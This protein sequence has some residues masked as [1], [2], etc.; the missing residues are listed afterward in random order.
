MKK[1]GI[2]TYQ[3]IADGKGRF[4]QAYALYSAIGKLGYEAE[5]ID[6]YPYSIEE[7]RKRGITKK[8]L[9]AIKNPRLLPG[10]IIK[11][12]YNF[13]D[14]TYK[15]ELSTKRNKYEIFIRDNINIT[16]KK[17]FG[18]E[19]LLE[20]EMCY[21]AYVCGSD[22]IWNPYFQGTDSAYFLKFAP[23]QKRIAY[24]PSLGTTQI[25]EKKKEILKLNVREMP[26]VSVREESGAKLVSELINRDV[27]NV[28]DPTLL[29]PKKW[30]DDFAGEHIQNKPYVLTFFFDNSTYPRRMANTIAQKIGCKIISIPDT[31]RDFLTINDKRI[32]IGPLEFVSLFKNARFICTQSFHG[33][34]LSLLFNKPFYVFDRQT[35]VYVSG[36]FSRI[37]E[38]LE[39]VDLKDRILAPGQNLPKEFDEIDFDHANNV[40]K[41]ERFA[42][43]K[44]LKDS[45]ENVTGAN[46]NAC[47]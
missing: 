15:K 37:Q 34:V 6:Y 14:K 8:L 27:K 44:F 7:K 29:L 2:I 45:L 20:S 10:Y 1:V 46:K 9:R 42:S 18:V 11:L 26:F 21:D 30:W 22:Q 19:S 40:I 17:Y 23:K 13:I 43:L 4:L 12:Q 36:V 38:L 5:I 25:D 31:I 24:A 16:N 35:K 3:D 41:K 32:D 39:K 28:I 47:I 33:T